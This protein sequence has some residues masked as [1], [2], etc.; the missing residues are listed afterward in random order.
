LVTFS[1]TF[2][3]FCF[4]LPLSFDVEVV[5]GS[6]ALMIKIERDSSA[7]RHQHPQSIT[8]LC[9]AF[10]SRLASTGLFVC[11][12]IRIRAKGPKRPK[13]SRR[14][15]GPKRAQRG[16]KKVFKGQGSQR[17]RRAQRG[18]ICKYLKTEGPKR[19]QRGP[20]KKN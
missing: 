14:A 11:S 17:A 10:R 19:A 13:G 16:P 20:G 1:Y 2:S 4:L 18:L 9:E 5:V 6:L 8:R 3:I 12:K 15:K 7:S